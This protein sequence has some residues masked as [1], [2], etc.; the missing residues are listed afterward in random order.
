MRNFMQLCVFSKHLAGPPL[1]E[2]ARRL[3]ALGISAIDLTVRPGGHVEPERVQDD[4]SR[5]HQ[6]LEANGVRIAMITTGIVD[7]R[8]K[9]TESILR[10]AH[11]LGISHYKLGY[12]AYK[13]FGT[14]RA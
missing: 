14:L 3:R 10:T 7:A 1:E 12:Y 4:L 13:G 2:T 5:A 9:H 8:E 6:A 11:V